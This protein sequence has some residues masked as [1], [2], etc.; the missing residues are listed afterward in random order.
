MTFDPLGTRKVSNCFERRTTDQCRCTDV[1]GLARRHFVVVGAGL[2]G[3]AA[4][5]VP[6]AGWA[7][8]SPLSLD[9]WLHN[10]PSVADS[11][12]FVFAGRGA[13]AY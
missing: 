6:V 2:V 10:N 1:T 12:V 4:A 3:T 7:A 9:A 8:D 11:A 5:D 13:V